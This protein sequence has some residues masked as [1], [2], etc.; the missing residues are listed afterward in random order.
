MI[1][2]EIFFTKYSVEEKCEETLN[3]YQTIKLNCP[4]NIRY[5]CANFRTKIS[6]EIKIKRMLIHFEISLFRAEEKYRQVH[7]SLKVSRPDQAKIAIN[8]RVVMKQI[9]NNQEP[10]QHD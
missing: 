1:F 3:F 5:E 8:P 9:K 2:Y 7:L 6:I 10:N 4:K